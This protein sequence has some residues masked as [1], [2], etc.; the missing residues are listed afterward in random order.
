MVIIFYISS[1]SEPPLPPQITDKQGH[2]LGYA[3]LGLLM[4]RAV[5][6]GRRE[7]VGWRTLVVAVVLVTLYGATDEFHQSFVPGRG[8]DVHDLGADAV[9]AAIGGIALWAWGIIGPVLT[10][11]HTR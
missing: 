3:G 7:R 4:L 2:S 6:D 8:A 5:S 11:F 1:L 10:R 9:G